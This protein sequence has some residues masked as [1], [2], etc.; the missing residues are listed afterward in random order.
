MIT[1]EHHK[2]ALDN[3]RLVSDH[4]GIPPEFLK[5]SIM[6]VD[7][8]LSDGERIWCEATHSGTCWEITS[9]TTV[10]FHAEDIPWDPE[11]FLHLQEPA[12]R[13][14]VEHCNTQI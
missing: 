1:L 2:K 4:L 13:W 11:E 10:L 12:V 3:I 7:A 8:T 5:G 6:K 9:R 14:L